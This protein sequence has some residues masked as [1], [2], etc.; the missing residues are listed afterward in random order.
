[1]DV[2]LFIFEVQLTFNT[3]LIPG[4]QEM[5]FYTLPNDHY[6]KSS[7][8]LSQYKSI[9]WLLTT[10]P[11]DIS[12]LWLSDFVTE[13]LGLLVALTYFS[14]PPTPAPLIAT[15]CSLSL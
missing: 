12:Y 6:I 7:Y 2:C 13:S 10:F 11:D 15:I 9:M 1:M 4:T 8:P 3:M 5:Y 14:P